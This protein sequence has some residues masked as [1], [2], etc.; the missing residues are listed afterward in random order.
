MSK[1]FQI[2]ANLTLAPEHIANVRKDVKK[3]ERQLLDAG[4]WVTVARTRVE[5]A[6]NDAL[7]RITMEI[8]GPKCDSAS[9]ARTKLIAF[10]ERAVATYSAAF[11]ALGF[12]LGHT[13]E[14]VFDERPD[15]QTRPV[16]ESV[17]EPVSV[18]LVKAKAERDTVKAERDKAERDKAEIDAR[19]AL[20]VSNMEA[21]AL[22]E[23]TMYEATI[24]QLRTERDGALE[25][26][27]IAQENATRNELAALRLAEI[28]RVTPEE[29]V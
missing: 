21:S 1:Q 18:Q 23:R 24:A 14:N 9:G 13:D 12:A 3:I 28:E 7:V 16:G 4:E 11:D 20:T 22:A 15:L 8:S 19:L 6:D 5:N 17:P 2:Y 27:R 25:G 10:A 26:R 29:I